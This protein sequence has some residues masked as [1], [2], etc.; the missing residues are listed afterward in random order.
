MRTSTKSIGPAEPPGSQPFI[1]DIISKPDDFLPRLVYADWLEENGHHERAGQIR[2]DRLTDHESFGRTP[3]A[4]NWRRL[5]SHQLSQV[6]PKSVEVLVD[7][8]PREGTDWL[9]ESGTWVIGQRV[10]VNF[11][12]GFVSGLACP[13]RRLVKIL[14]KLVRVCP[15]SQVFPSSEFFEF[16]HYA[17]HVPLDQMDSKRRVIG[18]LSNRIPDGVWSRLTPDAKVNRNWFGDYRVYPDLPTLRS[19]LSAALISWAWS[20]P[21]TVA[22]PAPPVG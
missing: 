14:P 3:R 22:P 13:M 19:D 8:I 21:A 12:Y 9:E 7:T 16:E 1:A 20:Q 2:V 6:L 5:A 18:L 17:V 11:R 4:R 10:I 15:V